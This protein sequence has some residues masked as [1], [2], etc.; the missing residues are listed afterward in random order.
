MSVERLVPAPW[1]TAGLKNAASPLA[2]GSLDVVVVEVS[3]ELR[4]VIGEVAGVVLVRVRQIHRGTA[5]HRHV[6]VR[7][8][9]L[10]GQR[11]RQTVDVCGEC[12]RLRL[13]HEAEVIVA[14][15]GLS[16]AAGIDDVDLRGHL[17]ARTQ[18]GNADQVDEVVGVVGGKRLRVADRKLLQPVPDAVVGSGLGEVV[19]ARGAA[20]PLL[21]DQCVERGGGP[22]DDIEIV[23][24]ALED[25]DPGTVGKYLD[26]FALDLGPALGWWRSSGADR[27]ASYTTTPRTISAAW[28]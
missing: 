28:G 3:L 14:V 7:D 2:K 12:A 9:T 26:E 10:Q 17:V 21:G 16:G 23:V 15:R 13:T 20:R 5:L 1:K 4:S 22:V 6:R 11:G 8:G 18:P 24:G 27:A 25:D 19:S